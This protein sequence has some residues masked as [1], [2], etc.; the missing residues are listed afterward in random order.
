MNILLIEDEPQ[1]AQSIKQG[2]E[3]NGWVVDLAED[4]L[5][6]LS[7][8]K[9][10]TYNVIVS[11]IKL[12]G[13]T[14][15]D[16]LREARVAGIKT[17]V[18]LLTALGQTE[19]KA[20]GFDAGSDDYLTKPFV[21][22]ELLMRVRALARRPV[23]TYMPESVLRFGDLELNLA[24]KD[25][26][27]GDQKINLTPREFDLLEYLMKNPGRVISKTEIAEKV[28]NL[29]FDTGTNFVEV[30]VNFLRKKIESGF[31]TKLIH[32]QFKMGYILREE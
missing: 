23:N 16:L 24:T 3:E 32:T 13:L 17:P 31:D 4:G 14:G 9:R 27:R 15:L 6:G 11:D 5:E 20:A 25:A 10:N 22:Q 18:L 2:F 1:L 8:A 19:D 26:K 28:W 7:M 21:F 29:D 30:Y 12:P